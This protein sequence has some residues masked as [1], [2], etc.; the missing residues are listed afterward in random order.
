MLN[1]AFFSVVKEAEIARSTFISLYIRTPYYGGPEEGGWWGADCKLVA[2]HRC[3]SAI[4]AEA[5]LEK[6]EKLA[7]ELNDESRRDFGRA[8][9]AQTAWLEA[10]GLDGDWLPEVGGEA[11]YLVVTE[12]WPGS[13]ASTGTRQYE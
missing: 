6:V 12:D 3:Q 10:R 9:V 1:E 2:Y 4:E 8:C 5:V 7:V 13:I 11:T